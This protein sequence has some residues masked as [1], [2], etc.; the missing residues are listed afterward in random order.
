[1]GNKLQ[2]DLIAEVRRI[3]S[4]LG[5][6]PTRDEFRQHSKLGEKAYRSEF[7][8]FTPLVTAAGLKTYSESKSK[9]AAFE[10][11]PEHLN[12]DTKIKQPAAGIAGRKIL[13]LGDTHFPWANLGALSAVYLFIHNNPDITDVVQVGDLYDF[14][15]WSR[16]SKS[17][18]VMKPDDELALGRKMAEEMWAKIRVMLP[19]AKLWQIMGNHDLRPLKRLEMVPELEVFVEIKKWFAFDGVTTEHDSR[20]WLELGPVSVTHGHLAKLGDHALRYRKNVVCGHSHRGGVFFFQSQS[21]EVLW[22][23]NAG[24]LGDSN[25][26]PMSY[27]VKRQVDWTLGFGVVDQYGPRFV[28]L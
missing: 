6:T 8:G 4:E 19:H 27:T 9:N 13:V 17:P 23:L 2:A 15:S 20:A 5:H 1:M 28:P 26:R 14:Y 10:L 3:A 21:G 25:A 24:Y 7:G 18:L 22:E 11:K 16:F 12:F